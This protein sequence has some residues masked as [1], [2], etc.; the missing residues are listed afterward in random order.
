[1]LV[2]CSLL[3]GPNWIL[4]VSFVTPGRPA[5]RSPLELSGSKLD[6]QRSSINW[7]R[8]IVFR[9]KLLTRVSV[10]YNRMAQRMVRSQ[11]IE[12][13]H[14]EM[15]CRNIDIYWNINQ[16]IISRLVRPRKQS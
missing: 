9:L 2:D 4:A 13:H 8:R 12:I 6:L 11:N 7:G 10:L 3:W 16:I 1:M 5:V 14:A 15:S